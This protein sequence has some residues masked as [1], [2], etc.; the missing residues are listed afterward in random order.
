MWAQF[1]FNHNRR[2]GSATQRLK[3][4]SAPKPSCG[5]EL[6][7]SGPSPGCWRT[8]LNT[9]VDR[10]GSVVPVPCAY[11]ESN[12]GKRSSGWGD[13]SFAPWRKCPFEN[14]VDSRE[15]DSGTPLYLTWKTKSFLTSG[16]CTIMT[17]CNNS[18]QH[19]HSG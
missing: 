2:K 7:P 11:V 17:L 12:T 14:R 16:Q 10:T 19:H 6:P 15:S 5:G 13:R 4:Q 1:F 18:L 9:N 3:Q 8:A